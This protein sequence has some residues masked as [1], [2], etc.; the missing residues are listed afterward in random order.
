MTIAQIF[1]HMNETKWNI[2]DDDFFIVNRRWFD[3][4][5]LYVSYDYIMQKLV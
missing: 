5:K 3:N 4:W 1:Q 2:F